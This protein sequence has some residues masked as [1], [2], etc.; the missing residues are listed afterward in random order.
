LAAPESSRGRSK[1]KPNDRWFV[2]NGVVATGPIRYQELV[3]GLA[4]GSIPRECFVRHEAW[5]V[6]RRFGE[7]EALGTAGLDRAVEELAELSSMLEDRASGPLSQPPPPPSREELVSQ[8]GPISGHR[9]GARPR[10]PLVDPVGVLSRAEDEGEALLLALSTAVA[11]AAADVGLLHR[12]RPDLGGLVTI[13]GHG[14]NTERLL[15]EKLAVSDPTVAAAEA[16]YTVMAEPHCG[17][18]G[19]YL[20]GRI[21]RCI[22][23]PRGLAMVP[24][25]LHGS[26]SLTIEIGRSWQPFYAREVARIEDVAC[27]LGERAVVM[28]WLE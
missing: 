24:L 23:A 16:D 25:R 15:G 4:R 28:G 14:P 10:L 17:E 5:N 1:E 7:V 8:T 19:R 27:A 12:V 9:S 26:L 21:G 6:W 11:A 3:R 22:G 2:T 13:C 18:V 20:A